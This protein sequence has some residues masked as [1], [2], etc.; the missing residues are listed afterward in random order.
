METQQP[1]LYS[2][3]AGKIAS[4]CSL[5]TGTA[6]EWI[7]AVWREDGTAFPSSDQFIELTIQIDNLIRLRRSNTR[8]TP[9]VPVSAV[10]DETKP[11]QVNSY[12]LSAEER[13]RRLAQC[14]CL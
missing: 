10:T 7:A 4:V 13:D 9:R 5:L 1:T 11:M 3:E 14:L 2:T 8:S 12:H 6:L